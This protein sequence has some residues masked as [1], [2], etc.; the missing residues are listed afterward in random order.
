MTVY[1][2]RSW[3]AAV[4]G[5]E[6]P[7]G[8]FRR[9]TLTAPEYAR[10][11]DLARDAGLPGDVR[12]L[13]LKDGYLI[14]DGGGSVFTGTDA[15]G[16]P[17]RL[18]AA[19]L[20]ERDDRI[21]EDVP[22][23]QRLRALQQALEDVATGPGD[24]FVAA[25]SALLARLEPQPVEASPWSGQPL[26]GLPVATDGVRCTE[27]ADD[28]LAGAQEQLGGASR[29]GAVTVVRS[30]GQRWAVLL[31]PLLP[32]EQGCDALDVESFRR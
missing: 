15:G 11:Q 22:R 3:V 17:F 2:D 19:H 26:A 8:A 18:D 7:T 5:R 29:A 4:P 10:L 31:R 20:G 27:L 16:A 23:R 30:A 13:R 28:A 24:P 32:H 9:G 21:S 14:E 1:P 6:G 25:R 12:P